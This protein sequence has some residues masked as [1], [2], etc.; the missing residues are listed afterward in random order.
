M[1]PH[2]LGYSMLAVLALADRSATH[3]QLAFGGAAA[4]LAVV[5]MWAGDSRREDTGAAPCALPQ[6]RRRADA[7][8]AVGTEAGASGGAR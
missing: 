6:N 7:S 4:L 1:S 3:A 5:A 2:A 8:H